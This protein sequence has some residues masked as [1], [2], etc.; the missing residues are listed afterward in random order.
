MQLNSTAFSKFAIKNMNKYGRRFLSGQIYDLQF[1]HNHLDY[2]ITGSATLNIDNLYAED[3]ATLYCLLGVAIR[4]GSNNG[5]KKI[6]IK[7][8]LD[9]N[10]IDTLLQLGFSEIESD[11]IKKRHLMLDIPDSEYFVIR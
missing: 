10:V 1:P 7:K 4:F 2:C 6:S 5:I 11:D 3:K 9:D 8:S